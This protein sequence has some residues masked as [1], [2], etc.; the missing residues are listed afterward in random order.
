M[1]NNPNYLAK[2][3]RHAKKKKKGTKVTMTDTYFPTQ[4]YIN[5]SKSAVS[6][7]VYSTF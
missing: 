7:Y 4:I 6:L 1:L 2:I 3:T 5:I